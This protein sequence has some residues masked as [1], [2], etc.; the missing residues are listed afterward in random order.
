MKGLLQYT[1][2]AKMRNRGYITLLL[3]GGILWL[4]MAFYS[5]PAEKALFRSFWGRFL[6]FSLYFALIAT[7]DSAGRDRQAGYTEML[8]TRPI[9]AASYMGS[10]WVSYL[11]YTLVPI[12]ALLLPVYIY[13]KFKFGLVGEEVL[14]GYLLTLLLVLSYSL[15]FSSFLPGNLNVFL[16]VLMIFATSLTKEFPLSAFLDPV[17]K[18]LSLKFWALF[19]ILNLL[20]LFAFRKAIEKT[21]KGGLG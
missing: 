21:I 16:V 3:I 10:W 1:L 6:A 19:L 2:L 8:F 15:F 7:L 12:V 11:L 17:V 9:S 18:E 14:W 5:P 4:F 13:F 20:S